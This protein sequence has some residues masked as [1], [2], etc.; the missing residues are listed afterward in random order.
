MIPCISSIG[1]LVAKKGSIT[2]FDKDVDEHPEGHAGAKDGDRDDHQT[3]RPADERL[4][5]VSWDRVLPGDPAASSAL[6]LEEILVLPVTHLAEDGLADGPSVGSP[7][8]VDA[9]RGGEV[10]GVTDTTVQQAQLHPFDAGAEVKAFVLRVP[11]RLE[12][13]T[14]KLL[15]GFCS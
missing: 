9:V 4:V 2:D 10:C 7:V 15:A 1:Y 8:V 11:T 6:L 12:E 5:R 14:V 13:E 3:P